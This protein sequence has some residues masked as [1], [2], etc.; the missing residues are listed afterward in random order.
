[1]VKS[2]TPLHL[3]KAEMIHNTCRS[4]TLITSFNHYGLCVSYDEL[5]RYHN[6]MA[7]YILSTSA[8][9]I[10]L[11]SHFDTNIHTVAAFDNF[12]HNENTPSG[13]CSSHDTVSIL[14]QDKPDVIRRKP[15]ISETSVHKRL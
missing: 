10:P 13:L 2:E 9:D 6:N 11:P 4:K 7:S 3:L 15:N 1:M 14:I 12:D 8:N 5:V